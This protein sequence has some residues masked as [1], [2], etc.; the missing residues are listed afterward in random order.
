MSLFGNNY[1]K[2]FILPDE[3]TDDVYLKKALNNINNRWPDINNNSTESPV[4]I[5]S[6]GWG[7]GSTLVQRLVLSSDEIGVWGEPLDHTVPVI[8]MSSTLGAFSENW[9]PDR[10]FGEMKNVSEL[11]GKWV[12]NLTPEMQNLC[13]AHRNFFDT[14]LASPVTDNGYKRWGFK[15]VR[16]TINH[17]RYLK[18]LY[19]NSKFIFVFRNVFNSYLSIK[20]TGWFNIWPKSRIDNPVFYAHHWKYLLESF[21]S[22]YKEVDGILI[23][24]E[25][26][27]SGEFDLNSLATHLGVSSI[28]E[29]VLDKKIRQRSKKNQLNVAERYIIRSIA[30]TL[31]DKLG[32]E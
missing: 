22:D 27:I 18:W 28:D 14:W 11:S 31:I 6:A 24:Y 29:S 2:N 21:L 9:P 5:F 30:S 19:P 13:R 20:D 26:L 25:D 15:E 10:F 23:K 3:V 16:L 4:F 7:A 32:Y 8:K 1:V 12:A 17:A